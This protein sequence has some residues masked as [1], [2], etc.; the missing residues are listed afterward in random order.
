[1]TTRRIMQWNHSHCQLFIDARAFSMH[2]NAATWQILVYNLSQW[3]LETLQDQNMIPKKVQPRQKVLSTHRGSEH[4]DLRGGKVIFMFQKIATIC[5]KRRASK[6]IKVNQSYLNFAFH[7]FK[8]TVV[9][10]AIRGLMSGVELEAC[11][12][13]LSMLCSF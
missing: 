12:C 3:R 4:I 2:L 8:G 1:M 11:N 5:A 6:D 7:Q 10:G 9:G 13:I